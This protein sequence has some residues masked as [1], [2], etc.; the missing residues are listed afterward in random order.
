M[1][2]LTRVLKVASVGLYKNRALLSIQRRSIKTFCWQMQKKANTESETLMKIMTEQKQYQELKDFLTWKEDEHK[3]KEAQQQQK[4]QQQ[5][6]ANKDEKLLA[7]RKAKKLPIEPEFILED[8]NVQVDDSLVKMQKIL[9]TEKISIIFNLS[10]SIPIRLKESLAKLTCPIGVRCAP[11]FEVIIKR[12]DWKLS[13]Y[14]GY[15]ASIFLHDISVFKAEKKN[16]LDHLFDIKNVSIFEKKRDNFTYSADELMID[17]N[18][19]DLMMKT[20]AEVGIDNEFALRMS[21]LA[22]FYFETT[23]FKFLQN[24]QDFGIQI[25]DS[26]VGNNDIN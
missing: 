17:K 26:M 18:L 21:I 4:Q 14:C 7:K 15:R 23:Y 1:S 10:E 5:Q 9:P 25:P 6:R 20:L 13:I 19:Y 8:Y 11:D 24:L 3:Q 2:N 22:T 16:N 12:N